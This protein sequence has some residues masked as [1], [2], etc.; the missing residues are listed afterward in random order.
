[1]KP[2]ISYNSYKMFL[3]KKF[4]ARCKKNC[5]VAFCYCTGTRVYTI[6]ADVRL[7]NVLIAN[8]FRVEADDNLYLV[9]LRES[10]RVVEA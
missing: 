1:M 5:V 10:K 6:Y 3:Y 4:N 7:K 8:Y 2:V 9:F